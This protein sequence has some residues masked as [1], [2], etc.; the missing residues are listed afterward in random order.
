MEYWRW[1][2]VHLWVEG[3]EVFATAIVSALFV[4]MGPVR[5]GGDVGAAATII[6]LGGGA[7]GTFHHLYFRNAAAVAWFGVLGARGRALM[8]VVRFDSRASSS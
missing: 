4:K 5:V 3:I 7:L 8:V 2:V 6:F 1:W